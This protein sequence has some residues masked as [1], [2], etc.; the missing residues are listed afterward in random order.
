MTPQRSPRQRP[1]LLL[2]VLLALVAPFFVPI[3]PDL[4][5]HAVISPL[6][7]RVHVAIFFVL[8]LVLHRTG[9]LRG[10]IWRVMAVCL[11]LGAIT[12]VVQIAA[13]RSASVFDWLQDV[14]GITLASCWLWWRQSSR[15]IGPV[16]AAVAI[17]ASI[18]W[19]LRQ[20]PATAREALAT[21]A[22]FPVLCDFESENAGLLWNDHLGSTV[23]RVPRA[24]GGHALRIDHHGP[25]RWPG[26]ASRRLAWNWTGHDT[27]LVDVRLVEPAPDS[28]RVTVWLEDKR[29]GHDID[30]A[31]RGFHIGH[32]WTTLR[33]PLNDLRTDRRER[34]LAL[35]TVQAV[36]LFLIRREEGPMS[37]L[38]DN[39][40]LVPRG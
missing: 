2:A 27:L 36:S 33:V 34:P 28:L 40:R 26:T 29:S 14:Q 23:Q 37:L 25:E 7:D 32:G 6:G 11:A 3:A 4:Q 18:A 12:E 31:M 35:R 22:Q 30:Y 39:L 16:L 10:R 38:V 13:G 1:L 5:Q 17:L 8:T 24:D 19:P 21:Q 15:R 20:F 9:P